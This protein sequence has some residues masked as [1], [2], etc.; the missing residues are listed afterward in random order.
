MADTGN[1]RVEEFTAAGAFA[2]Q[3]V[4]TYGC[5][6]N[7]PNTDLNAPQGLA[8]DGNGL[9]YVA[10]ANNNRIQVFQPSGG[11]SFGAPGPYTA[12]SP[13][14]ICDTRPVAPGISANQCNSG[15]SAH[16]PLGQGATRAITVGVTGSNV[17]TSGVSA[18]VVNVTAIAPTQATYLTLFPANGAKPGTSNLNPRAGQVIANL[19]EVA[20]SS[21]GQ[22]D[23]FNDLGS[24]NVAIDIEGYVPATT[25]G[26]TGLYNPTAPTRICDTRT[27]GVA[28]NQCSGHPILAGHPLTFDVHGS[29]SPVPSTG[30]SAVV[31]NLTA[32]APTASTV[33]TAYPSNVSMPKAS[34]INL[35]AG[36]VIPNRV[37]VPVPAHCSAPNCRVTIANSVGSVNVAVDIDG[38]YTDNTGTQSGALFSGVAPSRLCDTRYGN[39]NDPGCSKAAIHAGGILNIQIAGKAGIPSMTSSSPPVA[40]VANVTAVDATAGTFVTAYSSDVTSLP[41]ASDLNVLVGQADTNLVVVQVGSDGT[42]NLYNAAGSVDLIVDVLGYYS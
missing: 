35:P 32:I 16:G 9:L 29:G 34:N 18:V 22:L 40:V 7:A 8:F 1:N 28:V 6:F 5:C 23:I 37:I 15:S 26:T 13:F 24:T 14:R 11:S 31:F 2:N 12:V 42:I 41:K 27:A 21:T 19:V 3:M 17:P 39:T 25:S 33:L 4:G 30:V 20:V 36:A 10:D 38:W